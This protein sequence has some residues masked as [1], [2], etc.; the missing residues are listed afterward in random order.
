MRVVVGPVVVP[1][2]KKQR[3]GRYQIDMGDESGLA[4]REVRTAG[5]VVSSARPFSVRKGIQGPSK[6]LANHRPS[7]HFDR[8]GP[9]P[10]SSHC[11][12]SLQ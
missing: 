10:P 7:M 1:K 5:L 3:A 2:E 6:A 9:L 8:E 4:L 12:A 11:R